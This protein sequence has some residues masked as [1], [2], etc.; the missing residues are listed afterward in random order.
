MSPRAAG[1]PLRFDVAFET[2]LRQILES[3]SHDAIEF[4]LKFPH[5]IIRF[6]YG[7]IHLSAHK[8]KLIGLDIHAF[9]AGPDTTS[10]EKQ[11]MMAGMTP[12]LISAILLEISRFLERW[13]E[14][15][16]K[17]PALAAESPL[18]EFLNNKTISKF[19]SDASKPHATRSSH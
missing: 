19:A 11:G 13:P 3:R 8:D 5:A 4:L 1:V 17:A 14:R 6:D 18:G 15:V 7:V 9:N 12:L 10:P 2:T 16:A